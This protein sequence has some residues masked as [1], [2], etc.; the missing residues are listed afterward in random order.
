[1]AEIITQNVGFSMDIRSK[2]IIVLSN[3][4]LVKEGDEGTFFNLPK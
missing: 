1:M 4:D 2:F 3:G